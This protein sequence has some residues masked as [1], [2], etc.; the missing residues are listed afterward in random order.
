LPGQPFPPVG[1]VE[2]VEVEGEDLG[3]A[4]GTVV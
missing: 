1:R 3:G 2:L 4:G